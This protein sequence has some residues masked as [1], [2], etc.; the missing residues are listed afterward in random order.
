MK[1]VFAV[2]AACAMLSG[3]GGGGEDKS[4][5]PVVSESKTLADG[6]Q[7][8]YTLS[9]GTY[10][11]EVTSSNNGVVVSWLGGSGSG[12]ASSAESKALT[13]TCT[14]SIQ[15]QLLITNPTT[16]GLGAS[17]IVSIRVTKG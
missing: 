17:E 15:G 12:C 8:S 11:V 10:S 4:S 2:I 6:T 5:P 1:S 13:M 9:A 14:L 16:F 7:L 3:C